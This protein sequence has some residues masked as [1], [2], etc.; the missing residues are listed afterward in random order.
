MKKYKYIKKKKSTAQSADGGM[1]KRI[2]RP[3]N[4][5]RDDQ[6]ASMRLGITDQS[7]VSYNMSKQFE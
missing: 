1:K 2:S 4:N 7:K 6:E 3:C 5:V